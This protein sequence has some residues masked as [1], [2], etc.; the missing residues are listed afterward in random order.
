MIMARDD[1]G[2]GGRVAAV[3]R[4]KEIL[5]QVLDNLPSGTRQRLA[6]ALGKNRS[7]ITQISSPA[8]ETPI[9][10]RHVGR[11]RAASAVPTARR[12][13]AR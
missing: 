1:A 3:R 9:P 6:K 13:C 12:A 11:I 10:G 8:Y 2:P 4:Y 5:R 7:F